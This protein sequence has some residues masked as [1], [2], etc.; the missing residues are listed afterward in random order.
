M[1]FLKHAANTNGTQGLP[2]GPKN[3]PASERMNRGSME[4][5]RARERRIRQIEFTNEQA[6]KKITSR[7]S[8][9]TPR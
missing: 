1:S 6:N 9:L 4:L 8:A 2:N 7:L 5:S 3:K